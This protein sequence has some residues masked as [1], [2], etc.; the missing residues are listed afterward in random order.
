MSSPCGDDVLI[1]EA[2]EVLENEVIQRLARVEAQLDLVMQ[3]L[4]GLGAQTT[5]LCTSIDAA[6]KGFD[7]LQQ[8]IARTGPMGLFKMFKG[9]KSNGGGQQADVGT[10]VDA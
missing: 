10:E 2:E 4:N 1:T 3:A 9:A 5:W 8:E 6:F 7:Q